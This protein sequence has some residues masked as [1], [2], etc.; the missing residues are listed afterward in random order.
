MDEYRMIDTLAINNDTKIIFLVIDGLGGLPEMGQKGTE[1]DVAST[2]NLDRIAAESICGLLDPVLP[3]VTPGS[4]PAHFALFGYDP[5]SCN[6]GR[7]LL[8]AA[9]VAFPLT[10]RD[11]AARVNFATVDGDGNVL[12]R[13]A[14]RIDNATNE[15][16]CTLMGREIKLEN[17][18]EFFMQCEKE[19]RAVIVIRG[20]GLSDEV[21]D[22]DPQMVGVPPCIPEA[23]DPAAERT[24]TAAR[25]IVEQTAHLLKA[26]KRANMI[27][28]RGF[29]KYRAFQ[30]MEERFKL[31][32]LAVASYPMYEGIARLLGMD[33]EEGTTDLASEFR[34]VADRYGD[35][36][37]F[38][39]HVKT[40]DSRGEDGDFEAKTAVI[41]EVDRLVPIL[42]DLQPDVLVV[43][44]DHST[45]AVLASH[46]WHPVPV[47]LRSRYCRPD[48]VDRYGETAFATGGIGRMPTVRLM[49]LA[50]ANAL[51]LAKYGA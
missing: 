32:S 16:L 22:T 37:F 13:R 9:G 41:E 3:G 36:D 33:I 25:E 31:R 48:A 45:P 6:I 24:A 29:A 23:L 14:G 49:G 47:S 43:T 12:D 7:G 38:Y 46:S 35:Y 26:E 40:T 34:A 2:P 15:R 19:H 18:L 17:G 44:A 10:E 5:I 21:S 11:V 51:R 28:L 30:T 50:L 20:E 8:S 42:L 4:G 1:L 27:L 39:L